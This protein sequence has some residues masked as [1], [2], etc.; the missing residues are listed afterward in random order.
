MGERGAAGELDHVLHVGRPHDARV[1]D[2][3]VHEQLVE[4]DVLLRVG[5]DEIV[6]LQPSDGEN[7]LAIELGVIEP[8][9]Q[10]DAARSGCCETDAEPTRPLGIGAGVERGGLL[11]PHL[12]EADAVLADPQRFDDAVD[13]VP[14]HSENDVHAPFDQRFHKHVAGSFLTHLGSSRAVGRPIRRTPREMGG[15]CVNKGPEPYVPPAHV[16]RTH[17]QRCPRGGV[18]SLRSAK[19][20][21]CNGG[22]H[23]REERGSTTA[24]QCSTQSR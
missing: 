14:R 9:E 10:M 20:A 13:A 16:G 24:S 7:R 12:D 8:V 11:V 17:P 23:E 21:G 15:L 3:H 22:E 6:E 2:A 1:V 4:L 19:A 5:V 18:N